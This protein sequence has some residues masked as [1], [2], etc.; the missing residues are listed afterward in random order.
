MKKITIFLASSVLEFRAERKEL[1]DFIR[2]LNNIYIEKGIYY[3]F[4]VSED[5]SNAVDKKRKQEQ[6]NKIIE[7]CDYFY[8]LIGSTIGR[9]T[10]EEFKI[11]LRNFK[12]H[13]YPKIYTYFINSEK[14]SI[15]G[16]AIVSDFKKE[17]EQNIGHYYNVYKNIDS[18][19]L[20]L[21]VEL[22]R[23][24]F[25]Y[26]VEQDKSELKSGDILF[27]NN[28]YG[29]TDKH[30]KIMNDELSFIEEKAIQ[31]LEKENVKGALD[32]LRGSKRK[33][34]I[35]NIIESIENEKKDISQ[36]ISEKY[37]LISMLCNSEMDENIMNEIIEIYNELLTLSIKYSVSYNIIYEYAAFLFE[38]KHYQEGL[39]CLK[40]LLKIEENSKSCNEYEKGITWNLF[41]LLY[42]GDK[43]YYE[44]KKCYEKSLTYLKN[45]LNGNCKRIFYWY[46]YNNYAI[47][48][49]D[50][51][52]KKEAI[53]IYK[54]ICEEFEEE[55]IIINQNK[56]IYITIIHNYA[57]LLIE[58]NRIIEAKD[59]LEKVLMI[60]STYDDKKLKVV[61]Y[62]SISILYKNL[63]N[64]EKSLIYFQ[65]AIQL[66]EE[67]CDSNFCLNAEDLSIIYNN[68]AMSIIDIDFDEAKIYF[69]KSVYLLELLSYN[70]SDNYSEKIARELFNYASSLQIYG[71]KEDAVDIYK[72][73][74]SIYLNLIKKGNDIYKI[75][76]AE[77]C[78]WLA[79]LLE[80]LNDCFG[81]KEFYF[82]AYEIYNKLSYNKLKTYEID[83]AI[84]CM[85]MGLFMY[86]KDASLLAVKKILNDA[87]TIFINYSDYEEYSVFIKTIL[88]YID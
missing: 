31:E 85:K 45:T 50:M 51:N 66:C 42:W 73:A 46:C 25:V 69:K 76:Y 35:R 29:I 7:Q 44:S 12:L 61:V 54:K 49:D 75:R 48:L 63:K 13:G 80:D 71:E 14:I 10:M 56:K 82:K 16:E 18:I 33:N 2:S 9:Y 47:L 81:A 55:L 32:I 70:L 23:D 17:L 1:G 27:K 38:Y 65:K 58:N 52:L 87:Q 57:C 64:K 11:A 68:Y 39:R 4:I 83:Y 40:E 37:L 8:I 67:L 5:V 72:R 34:K 22:L 21:L 60:I 86:E 24:S 74:L 41:G 53:E 36:Y 88:K 84:L 19:K 30:K 28:L 6:Y 77:L 62:N 59:L 3:E 79:V 78:I 43:Q 26:N 15:A 20:N